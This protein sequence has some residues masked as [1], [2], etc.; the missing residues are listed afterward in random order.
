MTAKSYFF[1]G[2]KRNIAAPGSFVNRYPRSGDTVSLR[3]L[4]N[5]SVAPQFSWFYKNPATSRVIGFRPRTETGNNNAQNAFFGYLPF[6]VR[7]MVFFYFLRIFPDFRT[8][9]V[10]TNVTSYHLTPIITRTYLTVYSVRITSWHDVCIARNF[11]QPPL[12]SCAPKCAIKPNEQWRK[13]RRIFGLVCLIQHMSVKFFSCVQNLEVLNYCFEKSEFA[14]KSC[15]SCSLFDRKP[16]S[17][18]IPLRLL[19]VHFSRGL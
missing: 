18:V 7:G 14:T 1:T 2:E 9:L 6:V 17:E 19:T 5:D 11:E 15:E 3:T 10:V 8:A 4:L 13:Y 16:I 12:T